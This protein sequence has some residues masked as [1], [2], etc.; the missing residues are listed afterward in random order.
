MTGKLQMDETDTP[1]DDQTETFSA[2]KVFDGSTLPDRLGLAIQRVPLDQI[3]MTK[4]VRDR[5]FRPDAELAELV[6]SIGELGLSNPIR[7]EPSADGRFEL[8]QG[9]RRLSAYRALLEETADT[10]LY[11]AIPAAIIQPG[12]GLEALYRSMVDENLVRKGV[13]LAEMATLALDYAADP[14]TAV[15]DPEKAVTVLFKSASYQKRSYIRSFIVLVERLGALLHFPEEI[16][17]ELGLALV[18]KLELGADL[19]PMI[20]AALAGWDNRS[21]ADEL[22]VLRRFAGDDPET[23]DALPAPKAARPAGAAFAKAIFPFEGPDGRGTCVAGVGKLE[24]QV[25]RDF[26]AIDRK[27]LEQAVQQMLVQLI[28]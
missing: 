25:A 24:I 8:I 2:G 13:S 11:G 28:T 9:F 19:V 21:L 1:C 23:P 6:A 15:N 14:G 27:R 26:T 5:M 17:R 12:D 20:R 10:D 3:D 4:L 18:R 16:P 22:G 7:L